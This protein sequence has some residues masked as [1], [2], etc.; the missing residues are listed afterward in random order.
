MKI[1]A[2]KKKPED[3]KDSDYY[4]RFPMR[5]HCD[6]LA[7]KFSN[8]MGVVLHQSR[9]SGAEAMRKAILAVPYHYSDHKNATLEERIEYHQRCDKSWCKVKRL[10]KIK[11]I[12]RCVPTDSQGRETDGDLYTNVE[13]IKESIIDAFDQFADIN[14]LHRCLRGL[15]QNIN[16]S[17]HAKIYTIV[18]KEEHVK[19]SRLMFAARYVAIENNYGKLGACLG[20]EIGAFSRE[21][22]DMLTAKD[23]EMERSAVRGHWHNNHPKLIKGKKNVIEYAYGFGFEE[24]TPLDDMLDDTEREA[25]RS[26]PKE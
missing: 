22:L 24:N 2:K 16:E 17:N 23:K 13:A 18:S 15:N 4:S 8:L 6:I 25:Y 21:E 7:R 5:K 19:S 14:L 20:K 10:K 26:V 3:V 1:S 9:A 11:D 12:A